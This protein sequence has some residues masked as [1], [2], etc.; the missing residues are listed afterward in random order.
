[1]LID[2]NRERDLK[3]EYPVQEKFLIVL[4]NEKIKGDRSGG[5]GG[6]S[7]EAD[8]SFSRY[9]CEFGSY[10]TFIESA[11]SFLEDLREIDREEKLRNMEFL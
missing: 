1:M 9:F 10:P 11:N 6:M 5:S 4:L 8:T 3:A 2:E 7:E